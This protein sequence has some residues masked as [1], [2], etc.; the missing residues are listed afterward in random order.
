MV[1]L[2][3]SA[4][5]FVAFCAITVKCLRGDYL[6]KRIL[7][8]TPEAQWYGNGFDL[9][10]H[11]VMD[12]LMAF[13]TF[14]CVIGPLFLVQ[15]FAAIKYLVYFGVL[16]VLLFSRRIVAVRNP[17]TT[18]Y[19]L[20]Y[21]WLT[22]S[23]LWT[24]YHFSGA[25]LLIKYM[26]PLLS[27]YLAYSAIDNRS[28]FIYFAKIVTVGAVIWSILFGGLSAKFY[29]WFYFSD[30]GKNVL[31]YAGFADYLTS[32]FVLP[33]IMCW[34]TGKRKWYVAAVLLV[35][36]TILEVVRTGMGG[37]AIAGGLFYLF[38][39][40][41]KAMPA[42]IAAGMVFLG[43]I[44]FVPEV[45]GKFFGQKAGTVSAEDI[46]QGD[47]LALDNI[48]TSGRTYMWELVSNRLYV[49][50]EACGSGLGSANAV[51]KNISKRDRSIPELLHNDYV[52][53]QCDGGNVALGL[54]IA[55]FVVSLY[56]VGKDVWHEQDTIVRASGIAAIA[57]MGGI[58]FSMYFD[59]VVSHSMSSMIMPF[60]MMGF[61]FKL[62]AIKNAE[63]A[64]C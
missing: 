32:L 1:S 13:V 63:D 14:M 62:R 29:S 17:V 8:V 49:G 56:Y 55:F 2:I 50:N 7:G 46:V 5:L 22:F 45:N 3:L 47:A 23:M 38:K 27:L 41:F 53:I 12:P 10:G 39:D 9:P 51:L 33:L 30:L 35:L 61:Y 18:S 6:D 54:I 24:H 42:L 20:F 31:K 57:S 21:F 26:I 40:R 15:P 43:V 64:Y 25:M 52:Q 37:M 4:V 19:L 36:S 44:L 48:Q 34:L 58:A 28:D 16:L 60:I 11:Y 59:N